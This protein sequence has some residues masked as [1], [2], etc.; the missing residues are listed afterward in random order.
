[1]NVPD[2]LC[3][4]F[5][6][7]D[8]RNPG[9]QESTYC[10]GKFSTGCF[11]GKLT[12]QRHFHFDTV[13][14]QPTLFTSVCCT[15]PCCQRKDDRQQHIPV[16]RGPTTGIHYKHGNRRHLN[17]HSVKHADKDRDHIKQHHRN[18][19]DGYH[20]EDN[21][22]NGCFHYRCSKLCFFFKVY[23]HAGER[24]IQTAGG[25]SCLHHIY[26]HRRKAL[27]LFPHGIRKSIALLQP[28]KHLT[29]GFFQRFVFCLLFHHLQCLFH[30]DTGLQN[31][32]KL[33]AEYT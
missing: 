6:T 24:S 26:K 25:F 16:R 5:Q 14:G 7:V 33:P 2:N 1:M 4:C 13:N 27:R 17:I 8:R 11:D 20:D 10:S 19:S 32:D 22:I 18:N 29:D 30:R 21:G 12:K 31:T 3:C 28:G 9:C 15:V 23:C